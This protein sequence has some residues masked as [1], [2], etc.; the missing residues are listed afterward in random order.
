MITVVWTNKKKPHKK[1]YKPRL[2][3]VWWRKEDC[4][5]KNCCLKVLAV[6]R[7]ALKDTLR[8]KKRITTLMLRVNIWALFVGCC[9]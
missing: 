6:Q 3:N 9:K 5:K 4:E 7:K 2:G 1:M 8:K